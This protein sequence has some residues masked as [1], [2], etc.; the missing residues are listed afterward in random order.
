MAAVEVFMDGLAN[1]AAVASCNHGG[2]E[3]GGE[4]HEKHK[5]NIQASHD[6]V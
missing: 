6:S 3:D 1:E 5:M 2:G 4:C